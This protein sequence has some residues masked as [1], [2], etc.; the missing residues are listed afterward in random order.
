MS[1]KGTKKHAVQKAARFSGKMVI[2]GRKDETKK[3]V[4]SV[5]HQDFVNYAM[6]FASLSML[7]GQKGSAPP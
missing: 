1:T 6:I 5:S 3:F 7:Q 2:F 4:L